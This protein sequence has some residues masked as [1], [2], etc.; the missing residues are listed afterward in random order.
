MA[1]N[2]QTPSLSKATLTQARPVNVNV[3]D[4]KAHA[5]AQ[6]VSN[7]IDS[8]SRLVGAG[9]SAVEQKVQGMTAQKKAENINT[10]RRQTVNL[11]DYT[12]KFVRNKAAEKGIEFMH[13]SDEQMN[14]WV[15]EAASTYYVDKGINETPSSKEARTIGE[16]LS[17]RTLSKLT[18]A[19]NKE[20][21]QYNSGV[22]SERTEFRADQLDKG[23]MSKQDVFEDMQN[24][25]SI[26]ATAMGPFSEEQGAAESLGN[27]DAA[28]AAQFQGLLNHAVTTGNPQVVEMLES[29]EGKEYFKGTPNYTDMLRV[30]KNK[31]IST[32]N[33]RKQQTFKSIEN[34]GFAILD[35]GG[36]TTKEA[37]DSFMTE[38][39]ET[40]KGTI[41]EP[42]SKSTHT[43]RN[44]LYKGAADSD[45]VEKLTK[46]I[47]EG[48][49]TWIKS[50]GYTEKQQ[51]AIITKKALRDIGMTDFSPA[52]LN[53]ML[54]NKDQRAAYIKYMDSGQPVP[55]QM[56]V[57][58]KERPV[59]G[60]DGMAQKYQTYQDLA[61]ITGGRINDIFNPRSQAE[62]LFFGQL[63]DNKGM[64]E[65]DKQEASIAFRNQ[66]I[67]SNDGHGGFYTPEAKA[68]L[69][70]DSDISNQILSFS[71]DTPWAYGDQ[72]S[73]VYV[74]R[75]VRSLFSMYTA[76]GYEPDKALEESKAVF[77]RTNLRVELP[78][79]EEGIITNDF[80]NA[81]AT[82]ESMLKYIK[83][84]KSV[85]DI[86]FTEGFVAGL[87]PSKSIKDILNAEK[88]STG[89]RIGDF[90]AKGSD[91][92]FQ[93]SVFLGGLERTAN[94]SAT[95]QVFDGDLEYRPTSDYERTKQYQVFYRGQ[96]VPS[97]RFT[98]RD[99]KE[100]DSR[101]HAA[102]RKAS[103]DRRKNR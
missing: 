17:F 28:K 14:N 2:F 59:D 36:F 6:R 97:S 22:I 61:V 54:V 78:S 34:Q 15:T 56:R 29:D 63:L 13:V 48:D 52:S 49:N 99:F 41:Y 102:E 91:S 88:E 72:Q 21:S 65:A 76:I 79:G 94:N 82:P 68:L 30:A 51:E 100:G 25:L 86:T 96:L 95:S 64:T 98:P 10:G 7:D 90:L 60:Y 23:N 9:V 42:S 45:G 89:K 18:E 103:I 84:I 50:Q 80:T 58:A 4:A 33:T 69:T 19:R 81:G 3:K 35:A 66:L 32:V 5:K 62:M 12:D 24:N 85:R 75:K 67:K 74:N 26:D 16:G 37:V 71:K 31:S 73:S 43:L 46:A 8:L 40:S 38:Q 87:G 57:W 101:I 39:L 11:P 70:K 47:S 53:T 55:E 20:S 44:K 27:I 83:N 93:P 1:S 92:Q 77:E